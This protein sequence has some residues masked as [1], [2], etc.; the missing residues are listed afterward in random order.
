MD[1]WSTTPLGSRRMRRTSSDACPICAPSAIGTSQ[2]NREIEDVGDGSPGAG[3][4]RVGPFAWRTDDCTKRTVAQAW[5]HERLSAKDLSA[6][7]AR[8]SLLDSHWSA[9]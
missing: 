3:C 6:A 8:L 4:R 2:E 5:L 9:G 7:R 1:T